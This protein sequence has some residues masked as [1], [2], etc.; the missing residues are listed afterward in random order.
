[1]T[2]LLWPVSASSGP[3][4]FLLL[5]VHNHL[6]LIA[7]PPPWFPHDR[8]QTEAEELLRLRDLV[9]DQRSE[10]CVEVE[11][12]HIYLYIYRYIYRYI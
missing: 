11:I 8:E 5:L 9:I 2:Y 4:L 12:L 1:M 6:R 10:V 3:L 7:L